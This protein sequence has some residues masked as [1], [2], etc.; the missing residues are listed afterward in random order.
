MPAP[1]TARK[2][3]GTPKALYVEARPVGLS[4]DVL[5][6]HF[7]PD[8]PYSYCRICGFVY[9]DDFQ[10]R[11]VP[12]HKQ[13]NQVT[14]PNDSLEKKLR[15]RDAILK[16]DRQHARDGSLAKY[17]ASGFYFT[18]EATLRLIPYGI[19]PV[20]EMALQDEHSD[21]ARQAKRIPT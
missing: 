4:N 15:R 20:S 5:E 9:Q 6:N 11:P 12:L 8:Y 21:A 17:Q 3:D 10:R 16:H 14:E 18:P 13:S 19:I 1:N 7:N 2:L